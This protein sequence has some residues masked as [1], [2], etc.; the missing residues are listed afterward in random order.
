MLQSAPESVTMQRHACQQLFTDAVEVARHSA[1]LRA[2]IRQASNSESKNRP[3]SPSG[4]HVVVSWDRSATLTQ[5]PATHL[6]Q[7]WNDSLHTAHSFLSS[8]GWSTWV[9]QSNG[10]VDSQALHVVSS[11]RC[12]ADLLRTKHLHCC[13]SRGQDHLAHRV[14]GIRSCISSESHHRPTIELVRVLGVCTWAYRTPSRR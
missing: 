3:P 4:M 13:H 11:C 8:R 5:L 2:D 12:N 9:Q 10:S 7:A 14:S 1:V 6:S